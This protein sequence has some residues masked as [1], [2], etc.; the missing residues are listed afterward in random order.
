M[1]RL[2]NLLAQQPGFSRK[3]AKK[4][5]RAGRVTVNGQPARLPELKI[6]PQTDT[7]LLDGRLLDV[8]PHLTLMMNKPA[9][10]LSA[11]R[12]PKRQTVVDLIPPHLKRRGM[13]PAGRLDRDTTGLLILTNDGLLAHQML[14]PRFHVPKVYEAVVDA[15]VPDRV[16]EAFAG[17][18]SLPDGTPCLPAGLRVLQQGEQPTVEI[19]LHEGK[20]HQVKRMLGAFGIGVVKLH[21]RQ[22][23]KLVLDCALQPGQCRELT[24][25]ETQF[26]LCE[27]D[28][29]QI[30][31]P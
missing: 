22:V 7:I 10:V 1:Q 13:F 30:Y 3:E 15:P 4:C 16:I 5:I 24:P 9:G 19:V 8:K 21:R 23:G 25:Q 6:D 2:D 17:G 12:D 31:K 14:A 28:I 26:L 29:Q 18:T 20:Y 27:D 11:S